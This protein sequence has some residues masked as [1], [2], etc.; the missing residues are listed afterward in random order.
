MPRST[1]ASAAKLGAALAAS[2]VFLGCTSRPRDAST[3]AAPAPT[4]PTAVLP[5][6]AA[7]PAAPRLF[8][9]L[10]RLAPGG[11]L[12]HGPFDWPPGGAS[13]VV[14][15]GGHSTLVWKSDAG[16]GAIDMPHEVAQA[17]VRDVTGD[18]TREL[19]LFSKAPQKASEW[20]EDETL[21][22]IVGI[23]PTRKPAR[24]L[25]LEGEVIGAANE[26]SLDRELGALSSLG[27]TEGTPLRKVVVRLA[28]AT[29]AELRAL[30]G[31]AGLEICTRQGT[32]RSCSH[33]A[34]NA[35]DVKR[36]AQV[37]ALGGTFAKFAPDDG[38]EVDL[39][40]PT[41]QPVEERPARIRCGANV[42]GP[43]GGEWI[44][45]RTAHGVR[46]A[47]VWHWRE[48]S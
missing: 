5:E 3:V 46:L 11:T 6:A 23:A 14:D 27:P 22:W 7:A 2:V 42:R 12:S 16:S 4:A 34:P 24:M 17:V 43:E 38:S 9:D 15:V 31:P 44:F 33:V 25:L 39:S 41:C 45:E 47:E 29:P 21:T 30:V 18:A 1:D 36:V 26:A 48:D 13:A 37:A 19:V 35:I 40:P 28:R 8:A 20:Y 10:A 32:R